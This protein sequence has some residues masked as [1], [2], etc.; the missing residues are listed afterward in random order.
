MQMHPMKEIVRNPDL[1]NEFFVVI[2]LAKGFRYRYLF[3]VENVE[4]VNMNDKS[5]NQKGKLT[6]YIDVG[7]EDGSMT[8]SEYLTKKK[9][10]E[11]I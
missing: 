6:N 9:N 5:I 2:K 4:Y 8:I 1:A 10:I 3:E 7:I 11:E